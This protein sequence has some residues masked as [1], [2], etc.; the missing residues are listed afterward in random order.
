M[1][2]VLFIVTQFIAMGCVSAYGLHL[3]REEQKLYRENKMSN[4][5]QKKP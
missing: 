5:K 2:V 1:I 3:E 4:R